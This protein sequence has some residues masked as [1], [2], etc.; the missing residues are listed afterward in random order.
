MQLGDYA[1]LINAGLSVRQAML[2]QLGTSCGGCLAIPVI[3]QQDAW[4]AACGV[5][6]FTVHER[7]VAVIHRW[8]APL[9]RA[10][11]WRACSFTYLFLYLLSIMHL[12]GV[13]ACAFSSFIFLTRRQVTLGPPFVTPSPNGT[14]AHAIRDTVVLLCGTAV[15]A[16][17]SLQEHAVVT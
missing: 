11:W 14:V 13:C 10:C 6:V 12:L 17:L 1:I 7:G 9:H 4:R 2:A 3:S 16:V 8:R 15:V 5:A